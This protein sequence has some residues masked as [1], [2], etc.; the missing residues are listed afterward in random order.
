MG[1]HRGG[2]YTAHLVDRLLFPANW[3][4]ATELVPELQRPLAV[5]DHIPAG[6]PAPPGS[7]SSTSTHPTCW[8]C[9]PPPTCP[10][11]G[12]PGWAPRSTWSWTFTLADAHNGA[13][14]LLLRV[15]GR[16][17]PWWLT[18]TY[19]AALAPADYIMARR[20]LADISRRATAGS[21]RLHRDGAMP[22]PGKGCRSER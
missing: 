7:S 3:P 6:H 21:P 19:V 9:T 10:P 14:R 2:W 18:V 1:W 8:S 4:S 12:G 16:T 13:T 11:P 22:G 15:R 5:G 17:S 20:M